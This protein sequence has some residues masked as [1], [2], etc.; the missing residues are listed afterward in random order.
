MPLAGTF[1]PSSPEPCPRLLE[2]DLGTEC[3]Q[4]APEKAGMESGS[5]IMTGQELIQLSPVRPRNLPASTSTTLPLSPFGR[6]SGWHR[7]SKQSR[8]VYESTHTQGPVR[9]Q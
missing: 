1:R 6:P 2:Q 7:N 3:T 9:A 4:S 8:N 5:I